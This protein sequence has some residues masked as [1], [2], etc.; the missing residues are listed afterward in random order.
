MRALTEAVDTFIV[1]EM[2]REGPPPSKFF[3]ADL[4]DAAK[5]LFPD[6]G[7]NVQEEEDE[8]SGSDDSDVD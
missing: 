7:D 3:V 5:R 6:D 1:R 4:K 2:G 8:E